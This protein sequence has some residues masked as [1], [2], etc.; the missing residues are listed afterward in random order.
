MIKRIIYFI[1]IAAL[2]T[3]TCA[4]AL[5]KKPIDNRTGFSNH[6]KQ[7]EDYIRNEDWNNAKT[8]LEDSKKAWK[9]LKPML[10]VDIDHDYVN[11]I[12]N[13]FTKLSGYIDTSEKSDSLATILLIQDTW[14]NIGS[15]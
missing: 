2:L 15:L 9:K 11:S 7:T 5:L 8:S 3:S 13:D 12:E 6:L 1:M 4:C 14:D 10:Q